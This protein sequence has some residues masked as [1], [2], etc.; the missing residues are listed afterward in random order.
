M[1]SDLALIASLRVYYQP[2]VRLADRRPAYVEVLTRAEAGDG[3]VGPEAVV[4]AMNGA[5]RSMHLTTCIM[6][7]ALAEYE[8]F[9]F[10]TCGLPIAFN[11]PLDAMLHPQLMAEIE[12]V[13]AQSGLA[14]QNIRFELT[15]QQPV[16]DLEA[17]AAAITALRNAGYGL[18][19]DD[20]TPQT[21][22]LS[23]LMAM[24]IRAVKLDRSVV[25]SS[26]GGDRNFI[27]GTV[28][29]A[30]ANGQAV[31]AEGI[32]TAEL[33]ERMHQLGVTHG[34][35]FLFSHPLLAGD[36]QTFLLKHSGVTLES[37]GLR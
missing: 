17:A 31:I 28:A 15:E 14:A 29:R 4:D 13:R 30:T 21:P 11:L 35:G 2:I 9:H 36:L 8:A 37:V 25:V 27:R 33:S 20:I 1:L 12:A 19:L 10:G 16:R 34:Q 24:P 6:R 22:H 18:A 32:E 26:A 3:T 7:R 5:E 23:A